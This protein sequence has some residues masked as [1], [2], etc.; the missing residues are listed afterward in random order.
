MGR[1]FLSLANDV[2]EQQQQQ[3]GRKDHK[4][5]KQQTC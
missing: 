1:S 3:T 2:Q 4:A 5:E